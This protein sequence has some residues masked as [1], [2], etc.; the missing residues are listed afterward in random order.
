MVSIKEL[1]IYSDIIKEFNYSFGSF[2]V[3][4]GFVVSEI[5]SG[6]SF[7]W[8]NHGKQAVEDIFSFLDT[9]GSD[10]I[11]ISNRINS[12]SVVP[13]D[14]LKFKKNNYNLKEYYI[15]SKTKASKLSLL[16]ESL[17]YTKKIRRFDSIHSAINWAQK[18]II[19]II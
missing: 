13:S 12:Y 10:I 19:G 2:F 15:V 11:F 9:D 3:F 16:V 7:S 17:F 1:S 14:W 18:G 8:D 4:R 5:N 6:V